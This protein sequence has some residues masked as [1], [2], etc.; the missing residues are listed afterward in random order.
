[1]RTGVP[2]LLPCPDGHIREVYGP[3]MP[4]H[5]PPQAVP[6]AP[7]V[8]PPQQDAKLDTEELGSQVVPSARFVRAVPEP[9]L[10]WLPLANYDPMHAAQVYQNNQTYLVRTSLDR[11]VVRERALE[12]EQWYLRYYGP[13]DLCLPQLQKIMDRRPRARKN[14]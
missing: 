6:T 8:I 14:Q 10:Q 5:L 2:R 1:M 4:V 13:H 7:Y 12:L 3:D 11:D 9:A